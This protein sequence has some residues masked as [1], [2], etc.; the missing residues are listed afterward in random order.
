MPLHLCTPVL[1][2]RVLSELTGLDIWLKMDAYQPTGSFKI[3]GIGALCE[4]A[5]NS[6]AQA[7]VS[8]SGGNAGYAAAY[9]AHGLGKSITVIVP[10]TTPESMRRLIERQ[11]AELIVHGEAWDEADQEAR[12]L[13]QQTGAVYVPP[14]NH[15]DLWEGHASLIAE[16]QQ[17][18]PKPDAV[19]L[20][21]GGGGL[22][23]GV[24][25]GMHAAGW[26]QVPVLAL[27]TAGAASYA[28]ALKAGTCVA[29][30]KI[31]TIAK[32]LG[33]KKVCQ[34]ALDW[35]KQHPIR[36]L[37]VDDR[38]ALKACY[39]FADQHRVLVEPACGAALSVVH[40][41]EA[42][43]GLSSLLIVVCGGAG[44]SLGLL[45]AWKSKLHGSV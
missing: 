6:G 14:F 4:K 44:V 33:A 8:S 10:E 20:S 28:A 23:C 32:T 29:L 37:V 3:R 40:K 27:E 7:F 17:Q 36:S 24:V 1:H 41:P 19:A 21:V 25:Q 45:E 15:P 12:R 38:E 18:M 9:A 35:S 13:C 42:L 39:D 34:Q 31:D 16:C 2:S 43:A 22:L 26:Q 11:G 30:A 5:V